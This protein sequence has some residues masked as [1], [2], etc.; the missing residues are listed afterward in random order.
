MYAYDPKLKQLSQELRKNMTE[1][2][3]ALWSRLRMKQLKGLMFSRQ[4]P[5]GG[6]IVDFYCHKAKLVIEVDGGQ[7]FSDEAFENDKVRDEF[8]GSMGLIVL[9]FTN[10]DVLG[11]IEGVVEVIESKLQ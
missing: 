6:Y 8:M 5:L 2:E 3:K 9:R 11:N 1:A 4:K 10:N 7:H